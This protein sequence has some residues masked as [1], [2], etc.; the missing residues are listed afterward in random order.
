MQK[1]LPYDPIDVKVVISLEDF[2]WEQIFGLLLG[3]KLIVSHVL[4]DFQLLV[5]L[6]SLDFKENIQ[7]ISVKLNWIFV[8]K[9]VFVDIEA[10]L[11]DPA[12]GLFHF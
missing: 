6:G 9:N 1:H 11:I 8:L 4:Y 5:S 2:L 10:F 3:N 7:L 12:E